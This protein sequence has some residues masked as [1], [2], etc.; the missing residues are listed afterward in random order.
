MQSKAALWLLIMISLVAAFSLP[1]EHVF[2]KRVPMGHPSLFVTLYA[3]SDPR[4]DFVIVEDANTIGTLKT[5]IDT[6]LYTIFD[7]I[8]LPEIRKEFAARAGIYSDNYVESIR[9]YLDMQESRLDILIEKVS[10]DYGC[11]DEGC[12]QRKVSVNIPAELRL[13]HFNNIG[14]AIAVYEWMESGGAYEQLVERILMKALKEAK[15]LFSEGANVLENNRE[16]LLE[17]DTIIEHILLR[18]YEDISRVSVLFLPS[19]IGV[20]SSAKKPIDAVITSNSY[21][22][23]YWSSSSQER[24][25]E[26][27]SPEMLQE[28]EKIGIAEQDCSDITILQNRRHQIPLSDEE[29]EIIAEQQNQINNSMYMIGIGAAIAGAVAFLALRRRK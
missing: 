18:Q 11:S 10:G 15:F 6:R 27:P 8:V 4:F 28:C 5:D 19:E 2:A 20:A 9:A 14:F 1:P 12:A 17:D 26:D 16:L 24:L 23:R 25:K 13:S 29:R 7:M 3:G 22:E 21:Y